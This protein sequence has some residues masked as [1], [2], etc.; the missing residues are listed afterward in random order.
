MKK[1]V[2]VGV[3]VLILGLSF[4]PSINAS[5]KKDKN[6]V[7]ITTSYIDTIS[8]NSQKIKFSREDANR[9]KELFE[10]CKER[11]GRAD[12]FEDITEIFNCLIQDLESF[13]LL[14]NK[15]TFSGSQ[16]PTIQLD[17]PPYINRNICCRIIG[18]TT[19]TR[20]HHLLGNLY[21]IIEFGH[22]ETRGYGIYLIPA[23]GWVWTYGL[24][25]IK[26]W[27]GAINGVFLYPLNLMPLIGVIGF[28]GIMI[29]LDGLTYF[30][31]H[32]LYVRITDDFIYY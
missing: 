26:L 23:E 31:G 17:G 6:L 5:I 1:L 13:G 9:I 32:A 16:Q 24:F 28:R 21:Q 11:L 12:S 10:I 8:I 18:N 4:A 14:P 7:E 20:F 3:I 29:K 2:S 30:T 15:I 25:G 27:E 22:I 19:D